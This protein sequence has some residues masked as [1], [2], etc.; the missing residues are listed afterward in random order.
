[1]YRD[2]REVVGLSRDEAAFRLHIGTRTLA[3]YEAQERMPA[4]DVVL[5]MSREY[6]RP[7]LTVRYCRECPIG[8]AYSYEYLNNIDNSIPAVTLKLISELKEAAQ[9]MDTILEISVNK[10]SKE[11]FTEKDWAQFVQAIHELLDVEH[12]IEILKLVLEYLT[13]EVDLIPNLVK[14]HNYKCWDRGYVRKEKAPAFA[15]A[16]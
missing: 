2:A 10:H 9:A 16:R 7:D 12:N 13:P 14:E 4:P 15:G 6:K 11:D 8:D 5:N 3:Y 1:M